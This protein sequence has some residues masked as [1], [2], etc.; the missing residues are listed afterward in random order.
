MGE[1]AR[2]ALGSAELTAVADRG[3]YKNEQILQCTNAGITALVPKALTS[4][5]RAEGRF[6]KQDFIY[7]A[8]SDEYRCPAGQRAIRRY[9]TVESGLT[10]HKYWSSACPRCPIRSQCTTGEN[11]RITRWEHEAVLEAMQDR[12]DR[13]PQIMRLRRETVEHPFGTLKL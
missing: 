13:H 7:L 10:I 8:D 12:L 5:S 6:D 11:R 3:Y 2:Q 9:T 1:K 4:G